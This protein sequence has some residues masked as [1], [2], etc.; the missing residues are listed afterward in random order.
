M[1][2]SDLP[3]KWRKEAAR[4]RKRPTE[5]LGDLYSGKARVSQLELCATDLEDALREQEKGDDGD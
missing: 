3:K 2:I 4:I 5:S 1:K